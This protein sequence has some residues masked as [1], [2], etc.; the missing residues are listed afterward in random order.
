MVE[1]AELQKYNAQSTDG[2]R[3]D[4]GSTN[5][6]TSMVSDDIKFP[7][8]GLF[9]EAADVR[10]YVKTTKSTFFP[11]TIVPRGMFR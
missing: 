8:R 11:L 6:N 10:L 4:R 3:N 1:R 9:L 2:G 7:N 5:A